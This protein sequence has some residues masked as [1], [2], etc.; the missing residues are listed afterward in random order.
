MEQQRRP[1]AIGE[2]REQEG[3]RARGEARREVG[4]A[5][6]DAVHEQPR[7]EKRQEIANMPGAL[8]EPGLA[9]GHAPFGLDQRDDGGVGREDEREAR[10]ARAHEEEPSRVAFHRSDPSIVALKRHH[11]AEF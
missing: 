9:R 7:D 11:S 2:E 10:A 3:G 6:P 1:E 4:V 5:G 8:H